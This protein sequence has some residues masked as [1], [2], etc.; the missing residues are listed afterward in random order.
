[1]KYRAGTSSGYFMIA[2][3]QDEV[4]RYAC[5][6]SHYNIHYQGIKKI[7]LTR[8]VQILSFFSSPVFCVYCEWIRSAFGLRVLREFKPSLPRFLRSWRYQYIRWHLAQQ[9]RLFRNQEIVKFLTS[10][11]TTLFS[12]KLWTSYR[13]LQQVVNK[14]FDLPTHRA[15]YR[16]TVFHLSAKQRA[17]ATKRSHV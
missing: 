3:E 5:P 4:K 10:K 12:W 11:N 9:R 15:L 17:I 13:A 7:V 1:M 6:S 16:T 8:T 2:N 14:R